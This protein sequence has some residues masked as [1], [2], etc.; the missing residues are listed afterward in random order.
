MKSDHQLVQSLKLQES[1]AM[2]ELYKRYFEKVFHKCLSITKND[3]D[4]RDCAHEAILISFEKIQSFKGKSEYSTWLYAITTN[5]CL[6]FC[7]K[8]QRIIE[9]SVLSVQNN[10]AA[11]E[12]EFD[13][14]QYPD[15]HETLEVL[16]NN[17]SD[18]EKEL[19]IEKYSNQLTIEELQEKYGLGASAI[20]M[21]LSRAKQRML[22]YY[23]T[24][25]AISA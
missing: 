16:L 5:Y 3:F 20:K 7:K 24:T 13:L 17:I 11:Q 22:D 15:L 6:S 1:S 14:V 2:G 12:R 23:D 8:K 25:Y 21:R 4:A 9:T 10:V 19:L 18:Y